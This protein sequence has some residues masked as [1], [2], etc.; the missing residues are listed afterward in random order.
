[1]PGGVVFR[2]GGL[3]R[4]TTAAFFEKVQCVEFSESP[5]DRRTGMAEVAID[6]AGSPSGT[7]MPYLPRDVAMSLRDMIA[8]R[9]AQTS[10]TW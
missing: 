9:S 5:F 8:E 2:A 3:W 10:F 6:T 4:S 1:V 7:S